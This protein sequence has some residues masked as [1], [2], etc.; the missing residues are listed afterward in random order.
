MSHLDMHFSGREIWLLR[1]I[2]RFGERV[3][4]GGH[5]KSGR[6]AKGVVYGREIARWE[7]HCG[8]ELESH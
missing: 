7:L 1:S 3:E 2:C 5:E 6:S 4:S 8:I